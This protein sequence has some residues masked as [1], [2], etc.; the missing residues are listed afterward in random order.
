MGKRK[1]Q[2]GTRLGGRNRGEHA[3]A[4]VAIG[5]KIRS[6]AKSLSE[7]RRWQVVVAVVGV[8][9]LSGILMWEIFFPARSSSDILLGVDLTGVETQVAEKIR[10]LRKEV[11]RNPGSAAAWGKFAMNL[12]VHDLKREAL[13]CYQ[14]AA[15]LDPTDFR[16]QYYCATML[17]EMGS[18]EALQWFERSQALNASYVPVH[19]LYGEALLHDDRLEEASHAFHLALSANSKSS[20]AHLGL[21]QVELSQGDLEASRRHLL[22]AVEIDPKHGEVHGLLAEVYRRLNEPEK[23]DR[24]MRMAQQL[25]K[26]TPVPD[27]VYA[28]LAAEGVSAFWYETRGRAYL[29][30]RRYAEAARQFT[31]ALKVRPSAE[32]HH[33]VAFAL[34]Y[35]RK[36]EEAVEHYRAALALRPAYRD[37]L[38]NLAT[39]LF[40]LGYVEE[41]IAYLEEAKRLDPAF[42]DAYLNLGTFLMRS[43]RPAES[44]EALRQGLA[45]A[46]YDPRTAMKLAWLLSTCTQASLRNGTE[47]VR[48]AETVCELTGYRIPQALDVLAAAYAEMRQYSK[49][50]KIAGRAHPLAISVGLPDLADEI[51][52]RMKSYETKRPFRDK[53]L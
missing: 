5:N 25:P 1:R 7:V 4:L 38:N 26:I 51:Q 21:A 24:E 40:E 9:L 41:S 28:E 29:K 48:L 52:S 17:G 36:Y 23:A 15:E 46:P 47:A 44:I 27:S 53:T 14:Q 2:R 20:H 32:A 18:P 8:L 35:L 12:D 30:K 19:V 42:P 50:L 43:G 49:A 33:N 6:S 31:M 22:Q 39:A 45:N 13:P 37:A 16:W 10:R 11:E 34:Q 3:S